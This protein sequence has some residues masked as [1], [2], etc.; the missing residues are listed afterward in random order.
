MGASRRFDADW[1]ASRK[2]RLATYPASSSGSSSFTRS[3]ARMSSPVPK[4]S[5]TISELPSSSHAT[6]C[7]VGTFRS[8]GCARWRRT[9]S[10]R[11]RAAGIGRIRAG[12]GKT[13]RDGVGVIPRETA[14]YTLPSPCL[15]ISRGA[16]ARTDVW[17]V[18]KKLRS[19]P[20][21]ALE[22]A[23][24]ERMLPEG[25]WREIT[26]PDAVAIGRAML[27]IHRMLQ[28]SDGVLTVRL[29]FAQ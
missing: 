14:G 28:G 27:A 21:H 22:R 11:C 5:V 23:L 1:N 20:T 19:R 25:H 2:A 10:G 26:R 18:E 6:A 15:S 12:E 17:S 4:R 3:A 24:L 29:L 8:T 13:W 16:D 7:A 9:G